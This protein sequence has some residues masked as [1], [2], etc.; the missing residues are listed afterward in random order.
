MYYKK[1]S[2]QAKTRGR[3]H[4]KS[5]DRTNMLV[6]CL[7][8]TQLKNLSSDSSKANPLVQEPP[9]AL[10]GFYARCGLVAGR[11][12]LSMLDV[13]WGVGRGRPQLADQCL[14]RGLQETGLL[15]QSD[16]HIL[17]MNKQVR[18]EVDFT[19]YL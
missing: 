16:E 6:L 19:I 5:V 18:K 10:L 14:D 3:D 2:E 11:P 7:I 8:L 17:R 15:L 9:E 13:C 1:R 12:W 4:R